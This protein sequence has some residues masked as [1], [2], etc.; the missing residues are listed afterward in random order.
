[1]KSTELLYLAKEIEDAPLGKCG[2]SDD[3]E[4][5]YAYTCGFRDIAIRFISAIKRIGDPDLSELVSRLDTDIS[6]NIRDAHKLKAEL[7]PVIDALRVELEDPSYIV[8]AS[9][10][11]AFLDFGVFQEIKVIKSQQFDTSK[12]VRM[13]EEL[14]DCYGRSN[15]ISSILL[16]RAI[17]NHI[18]PVFGKET[19][20]QVVANSSQSTKKILE[21]LQDEAR[22]I[23]D[24]HTHV[25]IR[26]KESCPT[27]NQI[28]PYKASFEVLIQ[29]I[30]VKL[31]SE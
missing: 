5:Q 9:Q 15:Y 26:K 16:L 11:A 6:D 2:P 21:K 28:E 12:L 8:R 4:K 17:I 24:L 18:P 29:E 20:A 1:M 23:A 14:N 13:C 3:P 22:P 25:L 30:I 7:I 31:L 19:F 27:K 10:N